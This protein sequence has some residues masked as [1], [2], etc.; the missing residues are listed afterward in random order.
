MN[1]KTIRITPPLSSSP[2]PT[3]YVNP[4]FDATEVVI[5]DHGFYSDTPHR[6]RS[7]GSI[8]AFSSTYS[9]HK[10]LFAMRDS[11]NSYLANHC[12]T[13]P[14]PAPFRDFLMMATLPNTPQLLQQH[15]QLCQEEFC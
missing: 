8:D 1:S 4:N 3:D 6:V 10:D 11:Y 9:S 12:P 13:C 15:R 5:D 7:D 14:P 2:P